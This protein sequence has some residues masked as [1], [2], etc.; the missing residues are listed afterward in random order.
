MQDFHRKTIYEHNISCMTASVYNGC[1]S[2]LSE[3]FEDKTHYGSEKAYNLDKE[4]TDK[5]F[6]IISLE[7]F[8]AQCDSSMWLEDF[9]EK[10][11]IS[12]ISSMIW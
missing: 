2:I 9:L 10:N 5:F 12:Y 3:V 4:S 8:I 1:L 11:D 6:S 7:D